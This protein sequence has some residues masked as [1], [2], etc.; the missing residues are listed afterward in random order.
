MFSLIITIISIALVAALALATIYYGGTAFNKGSAEAVASQRINEGQQINGA[1]TMQNADLAA[2]PDSTLTFTPDYLAQAPAGWTIPATAHGVA[3]VTDAV[4]SDV[5][6]SVN[7]KAG[8]TTVLADLAA[9]AAAGVPQYG[10]TT[11]LHVYYKF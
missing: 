5:C 2:D 3:S 10:C 6:D 4:S 8:T 1:K 11:D 9:A 7:R